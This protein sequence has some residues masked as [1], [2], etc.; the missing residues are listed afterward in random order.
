M[1]LNLERSGGSIFH[2]NLR[3]DGRSQSGGRR[4]NEQANNPTFQHGGRHF[5]GGSH[6]C[7]VACEYVAGVS[8]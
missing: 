8:E 1:S 5:I 7:S 3:F 4:E 6:T 2:F